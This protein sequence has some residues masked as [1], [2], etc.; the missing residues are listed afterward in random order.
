[1]YLVRL[2]NIIIDIIKMS[3]KYPQGEGGNILVKSGNVFVQ[4]T[5]LICPNHKCICLNYKMYLIKI[6]KVFV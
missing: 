6:S 4:I 3:R 2:Q 1:M 5:E